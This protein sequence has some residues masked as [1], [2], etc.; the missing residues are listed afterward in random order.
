MKSM[1]R[2]LVPAMLILM[3][4]CKLDRSTI[5]VSGQSDFPPP[6]VATIVPDTL[7]DF[8]EIRIDNYFW[9]KDRS[10]P[11]VMAYLKAENAY[12]DTVMSHTKELQEILYTEM[13]GRIKEDDQ[14][15][16]VL[17]NGYYY[18]NRT[19]KDKQYPLYCRKKDLS[20]P[21]EVIFDV[22]RMAEGSQAYLFAGYGISTDNQ[23]AAYLFNTTGSFAEFTLKFRN[24]KTGED[25]SYEI[26]KVQDFAWANDSKTLFYVVANETLRPYRVYR[27][28]LNTKVPDKLI[29]EEKDELFNV[30]VDKSKNK[31]F[32]YIGSGSFTTTEYR[33]LPAGDPMGEFK[34]FRPRCQDVEYF[35][36]HHTDKVYIKYKNLQNLNSKIY[37]A[38][39]TGFADSLLWKEVIPHDPAVK[40]QDMDVFEKYMTLYVR[41]N[42]LDAITVVDLANGEKQSIDFPE[43]VY[44]VYPMNTPEFTAVK[45]RYNYSSLNRP[46]TVYDFDMTSGTSEK[47]KEQEIPG[48][49]NAGD[50]TVERLWAP[51]AD[52]EKVPMALVYK[53][54]LVKNGKNPALLYG[55]GSYGYNTDADFRSSVFSLVDRGFIFAI[56]QVRGGSE[57]GEQWYEDGK[58]MKKKNTF[59][60]FIACAE[61]LIAQKYTSPSKLG[62][63]GG[64]AGGLLVGAV[65][66][67]RPDLFQ[68]VVADV[69]F[70]DVINTMQDESLPLTTQEYEQ[71]GNP[72][73]EEAFRYILSYSPYDNVTAKAYPNILATTGWNDSQVMYHEPAKWVAKLRA[74]K[75]D[76]NIVLLKTNL[77]SGHGGATGRFDYL[78]DVAFRYAFLI[79]RLGVE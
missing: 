46:N 16:P 60:D 18:Y 36:Q 52:G 7:Q 47:L 26:T 51:A 28:Q 64:S 75:T 79:D 43:P 74:L 58:L 13:R 1:L 9:L 6:P 33:Y 40:I 25:L 72:A 48:G 76:N 4:A 19:E 21:E 32:I 55:Y 42:G 30:S 17:N 41:K 35:I 61:M 27:H 3:S 77:E 69:P 38:P 59:N 54:D 49:F 78:K 31:A 68:A 50:Y 67:M 56:A 53:K 66:N 22:N 5:R 20:G 62:I 23:L 39:V 65:A 8:G 14:S 71:W 73:E 57:M 29:Y 11:D 63:N 15:V 44:V 45:C 34:V 12:C 2:F 37:E 70:V 24:L 10:N